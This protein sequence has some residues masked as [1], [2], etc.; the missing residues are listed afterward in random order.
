MRVFNL[1]PSEAENGIF[2]YNN[3]YNISTNFFAPGY[4]QTIGNC[5]NEYAA[6]LIQQ[7]LP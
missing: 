7:N 6:K 2:R 1:K 4:M 3:V 5:V